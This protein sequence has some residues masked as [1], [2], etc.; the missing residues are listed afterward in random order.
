M[1]DRAAASERDLLSR[2]ARLLPDSAELGAR[3]VAAYGEPTRAYHNVHHLTAVLDTVT[4]LKE[5]AIDRELVNLAAWFHDA[6]YDVSRRDNEEQSARLA[7]TTL[8][9]QGL[10]SSQVAEVTRLVRLTAHHNPAP[11]D[12]NGAVL[13]DADLG[14]LAS[15]P[16]SYAG[17]VRAV[18][19]EYASVNDEDWRAGRTAVLQHLLELPVLFRTP[20]AAPWESAARENLQAELESLASTE[21]RPADRRAACRRP[22]ESPRR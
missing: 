15:D 12:H 22:R 21:P 19:S 5:E 9:G 20:I 3:L 4:V 10:T 16:E 13:C 2:W 1:S 17:Y 14:V 6:V 8:L 18:R 11:G 7:Q